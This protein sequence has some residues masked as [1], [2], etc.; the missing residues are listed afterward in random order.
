[1]SVAPVM[2]MAHELSDRHTWT[3]PRGGNLCAT[4]ATGSLA[5]PG[6][7]DV[8]SKGPRLHLRQV[9]V[10]NLAAHKICAHRW[11]IRR[12]TRI[13]HDYRKRIM[14]LANVGVHVCGPWAEGRVR[15][16]RLGS[17]S[18]CDQLAPQNLRRSPQECYNKRRQSICITV[19]Y[20]WPGAKHLSCGCRQWWAFDVQYIT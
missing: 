8:Q 15:R 14:E 17:G 9:V 19:L 6:Q 7:S 4:V 20:A 3:S 18:P 16:V 13:Q 2:L 1:M 10:C 5:L 11:N 12:A